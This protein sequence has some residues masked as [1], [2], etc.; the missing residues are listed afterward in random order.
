MGLGEGR[1]PPSI[2][3]VDN[4]KGWW[5]MSACSKM[6]AGR[7]SGDRLRRYYDGTK[8]A[9]RTY[10]AWRLGGGQLRTSITRTVALRVIYASLWREAFPQDD[11]EQFCESMSHGVKV[12][13]FLT[14]WFHIVHATLLRA[15][16]HEN[17][18]ST[19]LTRLW[20]WMYL[21]DPIA[22]VRHVVLTCTTWTSRSAT[23]TSRALTGDHNRQTVGRQSGGAA[24][25]SPSTIG[26]RPSGRRLPCRRGCGGGQRGGGRGPSFPPARSRVAGGLTNHASLRSIRARDCDPRSP[27]APPPPPLSHRYR[28]RVDGHPPNDHPHR[29]AARTQPPRDGRAGPLKE[30]HGLLVRN[31]PRRA[32]GQAPQPRQRRQRPRNTV[33][34]KPVPRRRVGEGERRERRR[35]GGEGVKG[36]P[37]RLTTAAPHQR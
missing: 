23:W 24:R 32:E 37:P 35:G 19:M 9:R 6:G 17:V 21:A 29:R 10:A 36:H 20:D 18:C 11:W 15:H 33:L 26:G 28:P 27:A 22:C 1:I 16:Y 2:A 13:R 8:K 7:T 12:L 5:R 4:G 25:R 31:R 30:P 3:F 34:A 14:D